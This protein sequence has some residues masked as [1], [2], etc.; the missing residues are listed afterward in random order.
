MGLPEDRQYNRQNKNN[1]ETSNDPRNIT[2]KT[3]D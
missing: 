2:T 3:E 1:K